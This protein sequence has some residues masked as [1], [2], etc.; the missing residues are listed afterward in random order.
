[1]FFQSRSLRA[2]LIITVTIELI[3][4]V[5]ENDWSILDHPLL[6]SLAASV[7]A[8]ILVM[9]DVRDAF[10]SRAADERLYLAAEA[11]TEAG[12]ALEDYSTAIRINR[13]LLSVFS[14][15]LRARQEWVRRGFAF[16]PE[17]LEKPLLE[18]SRMLSVQVDS[19]SEAED[20]V[21]R[22]GLFICKSA[23][24]LFGRSLPAASIFMPPNLPPAVVN[25]DIDTF[26]HA[27][28][29]FLKK[30]SF[31]YCQNACLLSRIAGA[32]V[33]SFLVN[34]TPF[35]KRAINVNIFAEYLERFHASTLQLAHEQQNHVLR[36]YAASV[37]RRLTVLRALLE[38]RREDARAVLIKVCDSRRKEYIPLLGKFG[39]PERWSPA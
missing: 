8:A 32:K 28:D 36:A 6:I 20:C 39:E 38:N 17:D 2:I 31:D 33:H 14:D 1:M 30:R 25:Q 29:V 26:R 3:F 5:F 4:I 18:A 9:L 10:T 22:A 16:A 27:V 11:T 21:W 13:E 35:G 24:D 23:E 7:I 15:N 19:I 12:P 34:A 37:N